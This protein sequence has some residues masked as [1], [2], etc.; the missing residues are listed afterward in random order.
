M[1]THIT[2]DEAQLDRTLRIAFEDPEVFMVPKGIIRFYYGST[3]AWRVNIARDKAKFVEYFYDGPSGSLENGLRRVILYR[4]E[5]L[6][7]LPVTIEMKYGRAM[8]PKPENR[9]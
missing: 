2:Y 5:I 4:H 3:H 9:I 7:A 1:N 6:A 8:D